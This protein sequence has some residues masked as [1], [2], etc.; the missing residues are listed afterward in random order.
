M[1]TE[2]TCEGEGWDFGDWD[3]NWAWQVEASQFRI[4]RVSF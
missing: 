1:V 3:Q 4:I 2:E